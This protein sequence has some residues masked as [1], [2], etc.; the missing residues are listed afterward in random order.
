MAIDRNSAADMAQN[1]ADTARET[2]RETYDSAREYTQR[3]YDSARDYANR[4]YDTAR[5]YAGVGVDVASRM[6]ENLTDFVRREPWIAI[7]AAFAVGYV[8][9]R[10]VRRLSV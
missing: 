9:A 6:S 10:V 3:G 5:E 2:A 1:A 4:G 8:V 7:A